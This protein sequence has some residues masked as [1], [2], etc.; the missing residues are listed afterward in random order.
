M[1]TALPLKLLFW[2]ITNSYNVRLLAARSIPRTRVLDSGGA[3]EL[4]L[5]KLIL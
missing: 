1:G 3:T 2:E 5:I 4:P